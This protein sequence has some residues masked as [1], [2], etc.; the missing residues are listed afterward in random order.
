THLRLRHSISLMTNRD[1][2]NRPSTSSPLVKATRRREREPS[3][4]RSGYNSG[5][6]LQ[7]LPAASP[8]EPAASQGW[9]ALRRHCRDAPPL[10]DGGLA[11]PCG[12]PLAAPAVAVAPPI[13]MPPPTW[14]KPEPEPKCRCWSANHC[15][16]SAN[17]RRCGIVRRCRIVS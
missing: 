15:R 2:G 6:A 14:A 16:R 4:A 3:L 10:V 13:M 9:L 8:T 17:Y 5:P 12:R 7:P 11:G 1:L